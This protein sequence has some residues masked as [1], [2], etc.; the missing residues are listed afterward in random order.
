[1]TTTDTHFIA[2]IGHERRWD[3][4]VNAFQKDMVPQ[5]L[6]L[7]GPRHVGK[8]LLV[9][10]FAQLLMC[11]N[12]DTSCTRSAPCLSCKTCHQIEIETFPDFKV[13]RPSVNAEKEE[14]DRIVAPEALEG[15][16]INMAQAREFGD[17]AMRRPL[18]GQRKIMVIA[19]AERM[20]HLGQ[21]A[22]LKTWEEPI[23][24][25]T[26]ILVCENPDFLLP[27]VRSRCWHLPV[28]ATSS[29]RIA[30]WL[31]DEF[32]NENTAR[33]ENIA[34]SSQ[35]LAGAARRALTRDAQTSRAE[36]MAGFVHLVQNASPVAA[37]RLGE[38]AS[39]LA[40]EWWDEDEA[41]DGLKSLKKGDAKF[42]RS[43]VARFLDELSNVYR[44]KWA[45]AATQAATQNA[46]S[47]TRSDGIDGAEVWARGLDQIRK[48]RHYILR[49]A[50]TS[51]ALD[52]LFGRLIRL[53]RGERK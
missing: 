14:R 8:T 48:T 38:D 41:G 39:R 44:T 17:E 35:G 30:A 34:R 32:P 15:S 10:R 4:L 6:L 46:T 24:G 7:S 43:Q 28:S 13:L 19:Q 49:N 47:S 11:P 1:M 20:E 52:V 37:L 50:N 3:A 33:I 53:A 23:R 16:I 25:L 31:R 5:T 36:Q 22:L 51:L 29:T 21:N 2:P 12:V 42:V 40:K 45:Q 26:I 9:K 27:T 18:V